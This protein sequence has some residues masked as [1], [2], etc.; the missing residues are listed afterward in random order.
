MLDHLRDHKTAGVWPVVNYFSLWAVRLSGFLPELKVGAED[1][2]IAGEMLATPIGRLSEREWTKQTARGL[3]RFLIRQIEDHV[4]RRL[5][6]V[7][8]LEAL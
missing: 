2:E 8:Y 6:T 1:R 4:E 3:R 7:A 5:E